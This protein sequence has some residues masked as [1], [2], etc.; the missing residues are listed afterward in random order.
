M[1]CVGMITNMTM[2]PSDTTT[3][4]NATL[5]REIREFDRQSSPIY[6]SGTPTRTLQMSGQLNGQSS[7]S[8]NIT[9]VRQLN[10][11]QICSKATPRCVRLWEASTATTGIL[12]KTDMLVRSSSLLIEL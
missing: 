3:E 4:D 6:P 2:P 11:P 8:N 12:R 1:N 10:T 5:L 9:V 7:E